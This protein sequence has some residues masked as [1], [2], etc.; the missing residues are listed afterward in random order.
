MF[1]LGG[2]SFYTNGSWTAG[3]FRHDNLA[4]VFVYVYWEFN[5]SIWES[6]FS[7][8]EGYGDRWYSVWDSSVAQHGAYEVGGLRL[9]STGLDTYCFTG[10]NTLFFMGQ[11]VDS[12]AV[13][14]AFH[15]DSLDR[16]HIAYAAGRWGS[17]RLKYAYRARGTWFIADVPDTGVVLGCDLLLDSLVEPV[18]A[19][20]RADG[21]LWFVHG[22]DVVGQTEERSGPP[23]V[24]LG[25][26]ATIARGVLLLPR[27]QVA[28]PRPRSELLDALGRKMLDL[29][30]GAN[31]V[32]VLPA[33]VYF[34][35]EQSVVSSQQSGRTAMRKVVVAR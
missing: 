7:L 11:S 14:A 19:Y 25:H 35:R 16:P 23:D 1:L 12:P 28:G 8:F 29:D 4:H 18:I 3:R 34:V 27:A 9:A 15:L 20:V 10:F 31:D 24:N 17:G 21:G 6:Y 22:V 30:I 33:G 26:Q 32:T 2:P 5:S 13:A